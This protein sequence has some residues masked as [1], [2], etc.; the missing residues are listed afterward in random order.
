MTQHVS[1]PDDAVG[2]AGMSV[3]K[4]EVSVS[5]LSPG[6][7][8]CE[9]DRPWL[10]TPFL[11]QGF[12]VECEEDVHTLA[13]YCEF[14][15]V[16]RARSH[17]DARFPES[18]PQTGENSAN[19]ARKP[20]TP[21]GDRRQ[22]VRELLGDRP[23][24]RYR[25]LTPWRSEMGEAKRAVVNLNREIRSLFAAYN[26]GGAYRFANLKR[27]VGPLVSSIERNPDACMWLARL[28]HEDGY[29]Y[30]HAVGTAIWAVAFGRELGL[31][32]ADLR[33]L[34]LGSLLLDVGTLH[35][36]RELL[37]RK[38]LSESDEAVLRSHVDH[39]LAVLDRSPMRNQDV[40]DMV[41]FHHERFD[42]SGYPSALQGS[43]IPL[44]ARIAGIADLYDTLTSEKPYGE[45]LSPSL[46][47]RQLYGLRDR[48]FEAILVEEFIQALG[49]YP[50]GT[51]VLLS[52]G[53]V[54]VVVAESRTRRLRPQ[55]LL[56]T[57]QHKEPLHQLKVVDLLDA[58]DPRSGGPLEIVRG[59]E[60][61]AYGVS[62][63]K[64]ALVSAH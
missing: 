62:S 55:V 10:E 33:S 60:P 9:L 59:L 17:E 16:D 22:R 63:E 31:A 64:I 58:V 40:R 12:L 48:H 42:G 19:E 57:D 45:A 2:A 49:L 39:S 18:P 5:D 50:A 34:A 35:I 29:I 36:P 61:G 53:E 32:P 44:F 11:M 27:A 14:V 21:T 20:A 23:Q 15:F 25:D 28:K 24:Q 56:L 37:T 30:R 46:A 3:S 38:D 6:M 26:A 47:V 4:L 13:R 7:Y 54:G 52:S 51:L 43:D 8:V 41:A 1:E